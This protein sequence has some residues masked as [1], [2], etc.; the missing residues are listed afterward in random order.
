LN[1]YKND[2][3]QEM[4]ELGDLFELLGEAI[5]TVS[6]TCLFYATMK[7]ID[8]GVLT[9]MV[10]TIFF[11][12]YA[13]TIANYF[14]SLYGITIDIIAFLFKMIKHEDQEE[15]K[16]RNI[17]KKFYNLPRSF[18]SLYVLLKGN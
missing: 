18:I 12:S 15:N 6:A 9:P 16:K 2:E 3:T 7:S 17:F 5:V 14:T 4:D 13:F 1:K 8:H 10:P 11:A